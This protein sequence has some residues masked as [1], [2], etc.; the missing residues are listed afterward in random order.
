ML[1]SLFLSLSICVCVFVL[2]FGA[3]G[4]SLL[5]DTLFGVSL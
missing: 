2:L 5:F 1:G 4:P 3:V